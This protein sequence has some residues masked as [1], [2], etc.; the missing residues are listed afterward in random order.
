[1]SEAGHNGVAERPDLI[2]LLHEA[3]ARYEAMT[4]EQRAA[5]HKAQRRS[6]VIG[7]M[8]MGSDEDEAAFRAALEAN[9]HPALARLSAEAEARMEQAREVLDRMEDRP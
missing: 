3:Q 8:G 1:M 9:D 7:E 5:M 6:Y 4:P 2:S